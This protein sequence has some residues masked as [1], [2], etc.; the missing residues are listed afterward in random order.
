MPRHYF[1][2][3]EALDCMIRTKSTGNPKRLSKK[4]GVSERTIYEYIDI[5]KTLGAP[6]AY[7]KTRESYYYEN[8]G[9]FSFRFIDHDATPNKKIG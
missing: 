4:L 8:D 6:I 3:L 5:L 1:F 2:R 9:Y 7:C